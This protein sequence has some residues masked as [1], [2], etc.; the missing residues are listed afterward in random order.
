MKVSPVSKTSSDLL[1]ESFLRIPRFQR[2]FDWGSDNLTDFWNDLI[3]RSTIDYFMGS[4]VLYRDTK[5]MNVLYLVDGQQRMTT[6][7][8]TL[9]ALRDTLANLKETDLAQGI[10][11]FL[12]TKDVDNKDRFVLEHT[13]ANKFFQNAVLIQPGN[14]D[15]KQDTQEDRN[16]A[17]ARR[18]IAGQLRVFLAPI[19]SKEKKLEAI[20]S[21]RDKILALQ[22]ISVEL[23]NEDDAYVIFETLNTR[24][25]DLRISDLVKNHFTRSIKSNV[26]GVDTAKE[27]WSAILHLFDSVKTPY[28]VD[29]FLLHYWLAQEAY[30][31]KAKLFKEFK[32]ST[33]QK[34]AKSRLSDLKA[35][36]EAYIT[37]AAPREAKWTKQEVEIRDSLVATSTFRVA[38]AIPLLLSILRLY[39][40]GVIRIP[41]ASTALRLIEN[42]TFQ[43]NAITQSRGG[44]GI[45]AM[46]A[47]LAQ[48]VFKCTT[49]DKF[50]Q[51][52]KDMK[53]KFQE[54][55]PSEEEFDYPF[56]S[57]IYRSDFTRDRDLIRYMLGKLARSQGMSTAIALDDMTIEHL[58]PQSVGKKT[59]EPDDVGAIGNLLF[60]TKDTNGKLDDKGF[61]DKVSLIADEVPWA[62]ASVTNAKKWTRA[63]TKDRGY[64]LAKFGRATVWKL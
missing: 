42:F 40:S 20:K 63:E 41:Q 32:N 58:T 1:K 11:N 21:L 39:R 61:A 22:Y 4:L 46:Y 30:V 44:G 16:L 47:K 53:A 59:W 15:Y 23:D 19:P 54:R 57:K 2:P 62:G 50:A 49:G 26:K 28:D 12:Q 6:T 10:Q 38:Q 48:A 37:I 24:G 36:A 31:S 14:S 64:E 33:S 8:I 52:L 35:A 43:F 7:V 29:D 55:L 9:S 60:V 56:A 45:S 13:P 5:E 34:E 27:E 18:F 3:S 25:K 51:I 17:F